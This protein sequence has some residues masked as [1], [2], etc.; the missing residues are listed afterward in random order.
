MREKEDKILCFK[1][2]EHFDPM[3]GVD[4]FLEKWSKNPLKKCDL[5]FFRGVIT[6]PL[7]HRLL[8]L[9]LTVNHKTSSSPFHNDNENKTD[10]YVHSPDATRDDT[11]VLQFSSVEFRSDSRF[12]S[13]SDVNMSDQYDDVCTPDD[14]RCFLSAVARYPLS[15]HFCPSILLEFLSIPEINHVKLQSMSIREDKYWKKVDLL[16]SL[17]RKLGEMIQRNV[18]LTK[19]DLRLPFVHAPCTFYDTLANA[20][21]LQVLHLRTTQCKDGIV[22]KLIAGEDGSGVVERLLRNPQ[23]QLLEL[24]VHCIGLEDHHLIALAQSLPTSKVKKI[25]FTSNYIQSRGLLEFVRQIPKMQSL[26][27][28]SFANNP[29]EYSNLE[30]CGAALSHGLIENPS[31]TFVDR[32]YPFP[33]EELLWDHLMVNYIRQKIL[34]QPVPAG[35]WPFILADSELANT[36][37]FLL[38]NCPAILSFC[39][40]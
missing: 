9:L 3:V 37:Y 31:I 11:P 19:L 24:D 34:I 17:F 30:E 16:D 23:S 18:Q 32:L 4:N 7:I 6:R 33:Q 27:M 5:V 36:V 22:A 25:D 35:L 21:H 38:R 29:W 39:R 12:F 1:I 2:T 26:Q 13:Q 40:Q 10:H 28:I 15:L 8:P 20:I 14:K